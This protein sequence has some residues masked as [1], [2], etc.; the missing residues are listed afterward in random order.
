MLSAEFYSQLMCSTG[1]ALCTDPKEILLR[2][3]HPS[4]AGLLLMIAAESQPQLA[5]LSCPTVLAGQSLQ[6][7]WFL[8][9]HS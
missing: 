1:P 7:C 5:S 9:S 8:V 2:R 4:D 6:C 3:F